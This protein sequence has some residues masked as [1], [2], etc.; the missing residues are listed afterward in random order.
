MVLFTD[1]GAD[2]AVLV[3]PLCSRGPDTTC[4]GFGEGA[5]VRVNT[6][7]DPWTSQATG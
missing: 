7:A 3:K 1:D 2:T 6:G 4:V 5:V